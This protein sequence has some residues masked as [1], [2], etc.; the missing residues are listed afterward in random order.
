MLKDEDTLR[1]LCEEA[2]LTEESTHRLIL[3][4]VY[5]KKVIEI[6]EIECVEVDT[7]KKSISRSLKKLNIK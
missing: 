3:R 2:K 6:A 1:M 7:I 5:N 4:Y